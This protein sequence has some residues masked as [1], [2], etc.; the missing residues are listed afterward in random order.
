MRPLDGGVLSLG[1]ARTPASGRWAEPLLFFF[2][3]HHGRLLLRLFYER[4]WVERGTGERNEGGDADLL[5]RG[6]TSSARWPGGGAAILWPP[7][8]R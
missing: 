2:L 6:I 3:G 1:R 7:R 8:L 5:R 4:C